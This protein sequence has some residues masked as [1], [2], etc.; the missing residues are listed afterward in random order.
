MAAEAYNKPEPVNLGSGQEI[1]IRALA[2]LI[3]ELCGFHGE[4]DWDSKQP[5][6][7]PRRCLDTQCAWEEFGFRASIDL[8][9]GLRETIEWYQGARTINGVSVVNRLR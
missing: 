8:R 1:T 4:I 9:S 5:D 3:R 2:G 7:Q 6:G